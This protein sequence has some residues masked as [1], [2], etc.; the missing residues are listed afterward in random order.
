MTPLGSITTPEP[1]TDLKVRL[2]EMQKMLTSAARAAR[3]TDSV[4]GGG[5]GYGFVMRMASLMGAAF[6]GTGIFEVVVVLVGVVDGDDPF[7]E[8]GVASMFMS[9]WSVVCCTGARLVFGKRRNIEA[10][11]AM[12]PTNARKDRT[13]GCIEA[14]YVVFAA[15]SRICPGVVQIIEPSMMSTAT[16]RCKYDKGPRA[17]DR[18]RST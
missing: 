3:V 1:E 11:T 7:E 6:A 13:K 16:I 5:N 10:A 9:G 14:M 15:D 18:D 4:E 8:T 17:N 12:T 2:L